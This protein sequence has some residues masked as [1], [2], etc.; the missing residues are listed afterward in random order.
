M[1]GLP[2]SP[3]RL[4]RGHARLAV[5]LA[6]IAVITVLVP[7][8]GREVLVSETTSVAGGSVGGPGPGSGPGTGPDGGSTGGTAGSDAGGGG[9]GAGAGGAGNNGQPGGGGAGGG[10]AGGGAG[11]GC[12]D[13]IE[14]IPGDPYSPPCIAWSGDNGGATATGV[15][16]DAIRVAW[17][18][19]DESA[20]A[21]AVRS[22]VGNRIQIGD[23]REDVVRTIEAMVEYVNANFQLYGRRI[24]LEL[25]E[26]LGSNT[27]E[28]S[29][30]GQDL[31]NADA[32]TVESL[33]AF[34]D[35][36]VETAVYTD[37][38]A[39]RGVLAVGIGAVSDEWY[40]ER[41]PYAWGG[42]S[43]STLMRHV[44][45]FVN[46][47]LFGNPADD[48]GGDLNG[49]PRRIALVAPE[50]P[51]YQDCARQFVADVEA[52][53]NRLAG[54]L[55]YALDINTLSQDTSSMVARL[56][57]DDITSVVLFTD[58]V[59][60]LFLTAKAT[61]QR[62]FP[63]WIVTGLALTDDDRIAQLYDQSQWEHA[64]GLR[65]LTAGVPRQ[66]SAPY[67]AFKAMRPDEE[68]GGIALLY[69]AFSRLYMLAAAIQMAGPNL[70]PETFAT[71]WQSYGGG[72]G[73]AGVWRG[74]PG[75]HTL[76]VDA[77]EAYWDPGITSEANGGPGGYVT[78]TPRLEVGQRQPG[79]PTVRP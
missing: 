72:S 17:R 34:A 24:E 75:S 35:A 59:A 36:S 26:G 6:A 41:H 43:C 31:A 44:A 76:Q 29:G 47:R 38:L 52:A 20:A 45:E 48:A 3:P 4:L 54:N 62:Y 21:G 7:S 69:G 51:Y 23:S 56:V 22:I 12:P 65:T 67:A 15:T 73:F 66:A 13:R 64:F 53:G 32:V 19:T 40:A 50:N 14:Q 74:Q 57:Q 70:T 77:E 78:T 9:G 49:R 2:P 16:A 79:P 18:L 8:T 28:N 11:G 5:L 37:A 68:P 61:Q 27:T 10:G 1:T 55:T 42:M 33:D 63:E 25:F 30:A 39:R 46:D 71:G 60:P 58:P